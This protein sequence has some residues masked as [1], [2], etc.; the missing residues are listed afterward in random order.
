[1]KKLAIILFL[2][3][4]SS[5]PVGA[6]PFLFDLDGDAAGMS[7]N[8]I[9]VALFQADSA[10]YFDAV[11]D[12]GDDGVLGN[13]DIFTDSYSLNILYSE[14][15]GGSATQIFSLGSFTASISDIKGKVTNYSDGGD[16]TSASD[17]SGIDN[18]TWD[19]EF[20]AGDEVAGTGVATITYNGSVIGR[21]LVTGG[22]TDSPF[23]ANT[24]G[25]ISGSTGVTLVALELTA[26]Y[27]Y[28]MGGVDM[29][30]L[31]PQSLVIGL[32]DSGAN[33]E[34]VSGDVGDPD[35]ETDD[36]LTLTFSD[37]GDTI[38]IST[39]PEPATFALF[40]FGL[41]GLAAISRRKN[42]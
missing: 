3:V 29:S 14:D 10:E 21:F 15:S 6:T 19:L 4:F 23:T 8:T 11:V 5:I 34:S 26:G 42:A 35:D 24:N 9:E 38:R 25:T 30:T 20:Y 36:Q 12:L 22:G 31:D 2:L 28:T 18:D 27:W 40:G 13:D 39:V 17:Y 41:L 16:A 32:V 37:N 7:S 33:L 1:M